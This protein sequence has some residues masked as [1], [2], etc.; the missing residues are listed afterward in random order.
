[1][2]VFVVLLYFFMVTLCGN[3]RD[4]VNFRVKFMVSK[5][6]SVYVKV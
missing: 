6:T 5:C 1:M 2:E 4:V 3:L